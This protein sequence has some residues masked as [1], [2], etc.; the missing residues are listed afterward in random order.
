M[1]CLNI[2]IS[3]VFSP[4]KATVSR[5]GGLCASITRLQSINITI[6]EMISNLNVVVTKGSPMFSVA[7]AA[8]S[9][10]MQVRCSI[11]CDVLNYYL[12]VEPEFIWL[13][14]D[15]NWSQDFM[16]ESNVDWIVE[17]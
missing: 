12:L 3:R 4:I 10:Y 8:V 15:N 16:V 14:E 6:T 11:V 7:T 9:E 1:A 2:N 5:V 17:Y 13:T